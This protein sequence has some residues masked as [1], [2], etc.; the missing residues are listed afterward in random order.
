M[1]APKPRS[2]EFFGFPDGCFA[3][4]VIIA[5]SKEVFAMAAETLFISFSD[6]R[7]IEWYIGDFCQCEI[8]LISKQTWSA[9]EWLERGFTYAQIL[10]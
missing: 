8:H 3:A 2:V 1:L 5:P 7:D 10:M 6:W 9:K 4:R